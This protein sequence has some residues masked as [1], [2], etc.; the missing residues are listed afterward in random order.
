MEFVRKDWRANPNLKNESIRSWEAGFE[1]RGFNNRVGLDVS[2]YKKN[3][4][5]QILKIAIPPAT[6]YL[7]DLVN[8]GNIQNQGWEVIL[9]ATPVKTRNFTWETLFNWSTNKNKIIELT[10]DTKRQLLSYDTGLDNIMNIVAEEGGSYGDIY[11]TAYLRD[12]KG[13]IIIGQSGIP[14]AASERKLLG[15]NQPD[16]MFGWNNTLTFKN[17]TVGFLFDLNYGGSVYMGSIQTGTS[18]GN[19]AMT[20]AGRDGTMI[21][22]GVTEN[23]EKNTT[24]VSAQS[25]WKGISSITEA[26]LYDATNARMRELS[27]GYN[28]PRSIL[29]KT[30]ITALRASLV[31]HNVFMIYSKTEGFDPEAGFSNANTVQ[32]V[33]FAS[34]P[35]MR[36]IGLNLHVEF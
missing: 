17:L 26:F 24:Q 25:Y 5:N 35:T 30:P 28:V 1:L 16:G 9:N 2:F 8:A 33:E 36:S 23:G 21:A 4:F 7:Y 29:S 3:A 32:G 22:D 15:N 10:K 11:G 12:D 27:I 18:N 14:L 34:M 19:L 20:L 6:G 13:N 31:A